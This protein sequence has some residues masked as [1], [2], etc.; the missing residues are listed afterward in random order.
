MKLI[1]TT[2]KG[3]LV[4]ML[5]ADA[6]TKDQATEWMEM[7]VKA[8]GD[9]NRRLGVIHQAALRRL[10]ALIAAENKRFQSLSDQLDG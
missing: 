6:A 3:P 10:T 2:V 8:E 4:R 7:V 1:E 5:Y 9:D